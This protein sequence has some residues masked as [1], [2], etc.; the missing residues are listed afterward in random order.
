MVEVD[1]PDGP[2]HDLTSVQMEMS[3]VTLTLLV[4]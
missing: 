3:A 1:A 4:W 2:Q